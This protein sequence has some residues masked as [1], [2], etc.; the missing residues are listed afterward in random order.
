MLQQSSSFSCPLVPFQASGGS[1]HLHN[2]PLS[3][4]ILFISCSLFPFLP[5]ICPII[6]QFYPTSSSSSLC[7]SLYYVLSFSEF[8]YPYY[9]SKPFNPIRAKFLNVKLFIKKILKFLRKY[10]SL[11]IKI[12]HSIHRYL[13]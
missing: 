5:M 1:S 2:L 10:I 11:Q 13:M 8:T 12:L 7:S 9:I 6:F 4:V 3:I